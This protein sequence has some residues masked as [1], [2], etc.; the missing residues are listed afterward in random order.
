MDGTLDYQGTV[1]LNPAAIVGSGAAASIVG[2]L[3]GSRVGK[4]TVPF[5]L[6]GT[7]ESP[8]VRPGKALPSTASAPSGQT[9][10][11]QNAVDSI[12]SLFKKH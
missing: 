4:I 5:A 11:P 7:I 8:K 1:A 2:G 10:T 12:K 3:L 6:E 9:A